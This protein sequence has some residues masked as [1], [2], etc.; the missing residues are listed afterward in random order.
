M[1]K[2]FTIVA[3]ILLAATLTAGAQGRKPASAPKDS[4]SDKEKTEK[5]V[6]LKLAAGLHAVGQNEKDWYFEV[7]DSLLGRRMLAVTRYNSMTAGA[8]TYGGEEVNEVMLYWEKASNDNLLL[9]VDVVNIKSIDDDQEISKAVRVS[10]E[11][12]IVASF[13]PE[14]G[15]S[16]G[17]TRIK[18]NSLFEGD[19]QIFS[20]DSRTKRQ[21]N[22]G[23]L[24][25][26]ASF[27]N[28]IRTYPINTEVTVTKTYTYNAPAPGAGAM[29]GGRTASTSLPAGREA[30]TVTV[31]LNTSI[32]L[33]PKE[34][35][36]QRWFDSRVG[37]FAGGYSEFSDDQQG[38][39]SIRF[40]ARYRLEARPE[41]VERQKRG[42]LVEPLKPIVYY[43][44]P[45]TPKQWRKYL[46]AGVN[47]WNVAFEQAGWKNAI[48][49]EEWPEDNPDMSLEDARF[50]VIRYLASPIANAYGPNVHD[51]RSGEI[52][53]SHVGWYHNVMTL[54]H[55]WYQIQ[56]GAVDP[57]A[58]KIKYDEEL[59]GDLIRFV[60]SHEVGHTLGLRHNMGASSQTPVEK[61]RDKAWVEANG[62]TVSIMDYARFNYV[63][64]PEDGIGKTGLYPR[65]GDYDKWAIE[66]GYK[67]TY[68]KSAKEDH[69]YWNKV[70]IERLEANPRLWFGGEGRDGDPRALTED[71]GDDAVAASNYGILNL[72]RTI[73]EIPAW[74]AE[75]AD[76]YVHVARMYEALIGQYNRYLGHVSANIGGRFLTNHSI[77]QPDI[78]KYTAVPKARQKAALNWLDENLFQKPSW[79]VEVP[80]IWDITDAPDNYLYTLVNNVVSPNNLL[81]IMKLSRLAHFAEY[82]ASNYSPEEYLSDLTGMVFSELGKGGKVD[83]YRRYLQRR[84]VSAAISAISADAAASYD[85]RNLIVGQLLDIQKRAAKA[86]SSDTATQAHWQTL[87]RQI[88]TALKELK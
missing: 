31:V 85:G 9:R 38:V 49:A 54:V 82:D 13:K 12:P 61:L 47:D 57:R 36:Q 88:E 45:A 23:G 16:E 72:K 87:S 46:I 37:Y 86:K 17:T 15:A 84:F 30:G 77:E 69:L 11:N 51:P 4:P 71:L 44:D 1:S 7:P 70:I 56:A 20:L 33:L 76:M 8:G 3:A 41:D 64:Q 66:F 32:V 21:Y 80:Y 65:I 29:G 55:D 74:N 27:I 58:R 19:T 62:H 6:E 81:S 73:T 63:A 18:V 78:T 10:S 52:I 59:M 34:P 53:E 50:C 2:R 39:E 60:S 24:K 40:I 67:P 35:M 26:D 79:L 42:E 68:L 43:I 75:E 14:K 22:L 28:S 48:H 83:S 25:G 5:P